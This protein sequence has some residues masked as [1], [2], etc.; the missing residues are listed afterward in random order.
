ADLSNGETPEPVTHEWRRSCRASSGE[1]RTN[2]STSPRTRAAAYPRSH[3]AHGPHTTQCPPAC[4]RF[5]SSSC[6]SRRPHRPQPR[7]RV[8]DVARPSGLAP[9]HLPAARTLPAGEHLAIDVGADPLPIRR[10]RRG[11]GHDFHAGGATR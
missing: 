4:F 10:G 6:C 8:A 1:V 7:S 9:L 11:T 5:T 3:V 2:V